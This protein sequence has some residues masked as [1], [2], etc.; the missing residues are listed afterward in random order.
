M[1]ETK[2]TARPIV[3]RFLRLADLTERFFPNEPAKLTSW[4]LSVDRLACAMRRALEAGVCTVVSCALYNPTDM[5]YFNE[6]YVP[7]FRAAGLDV[8]QTQYGVFVG[9][10]RAYK[11]KPGIRPRP[12]HEYGQIR[13]ELD[14]ADFRVRSADRPVTPKPDAD[15]YAKRWARLAYS[16]CSMM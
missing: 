5:A 10:W 7:A 2:R 14:S 3:P 9:T 4:Q 8:G 11:N 1:D 12:W 16:G 6:Q 15:S 13:I